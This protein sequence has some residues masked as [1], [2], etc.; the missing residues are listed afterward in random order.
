[1][2]RRTIITLLGGAA[3][4]PVTAR[5]Q[6]PDRLRRIGVLMGYRSDDAYAQSLA[7][8][9][10]QGLIAL[11]WRE[12]G[13]LRLDWRWAGGDPVLFGRYTAELVMLRPDVLLAQASPA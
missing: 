8:A 6:Q 12:G 9:L 1:M 5:A 7:A 2:N 4:W 13:N 3:A 10:T 11:D